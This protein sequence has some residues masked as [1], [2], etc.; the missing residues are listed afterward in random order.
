MANHLGKFISNLAD[1][2]KNL[3]DLLLKKVTGLGESLSRQ[4]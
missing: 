2:I 4:S 3:G 1:T